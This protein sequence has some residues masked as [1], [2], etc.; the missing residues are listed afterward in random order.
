VPGDGIST[1]A[2]LSGVGV[3]SPW[4]PVPAHPAPSM[5]S[6]TDNAQTH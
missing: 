3:G 1:V 4:A 6:T 2:P 5:I